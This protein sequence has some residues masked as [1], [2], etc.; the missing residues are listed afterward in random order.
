ML[1]YVQDD[2]LSLRLNAR[3]TNYWDVYLG[4]IC[5]LLGLRPSTVSLAELDSGSRLD[6]IQTLIIGAASGACLSDAA[7]A[8]IAE[9]V[10]SGGT[11]IGFGVQ[12]LDD[13]FG[14]EH[15]QGDP[16]KRDYA[17]S[18]CI[19]QGPDDCAISGYFSCARTG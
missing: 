15:L 8:R 17:P 9:W 2:D 12:G 7:R 4:E 19:Q 3:R 13:T 18:T 6:S 11:L 16:A 14:V 5:G 1:A 10:R